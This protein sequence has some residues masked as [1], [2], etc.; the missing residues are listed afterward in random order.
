MRDLVS[1]KQTKSLSSRDH[2]GKPQLVEMGVGCQ[3]LSI[4]LPHNPYPKAQK[5]L[6]KGESE[7]KEICHETESSM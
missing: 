1:N 6:Q 3:A 7:D 5:M 4:H 2:Y